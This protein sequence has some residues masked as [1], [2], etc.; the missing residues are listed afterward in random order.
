LGLI[1]K[2]KG[3]PVSDREAENTIKRFGAALI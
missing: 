2:A 3:K 1:E